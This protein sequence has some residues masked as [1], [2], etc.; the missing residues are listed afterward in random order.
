[1]RRGFTLIEV[2]IA[3][4]VMLILLTAAAS[5]LQNANRRQ[6][7]DQVAENV[8]QTFLQA[9]S[10]AQAGKKDCAFCA[11]VAQPYSCGTSPT[12]L[13]LDGWR[14]TVN[15][16]DYVMEGVCGGVAFSTRTVQLP[17]GI[18]ASTGAVS[19]VRFL[20]IGL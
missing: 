3:I 11:G 14:V 10:Y 17:V 7:L 9:K 5:N 4:G 19:S 2:I 13:P 15:T 6:S 20:P 18:V 1:M 8:R 12:E 16:N